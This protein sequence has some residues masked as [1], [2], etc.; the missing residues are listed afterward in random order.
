MAFIWAL[1]GVATLVAFIL[2][3]ICIVAGQPGFLQGSGIV[4]VGQYVP[5][6]LRT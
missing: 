1:R 3:L 6:L 4:R 5:N 2:V